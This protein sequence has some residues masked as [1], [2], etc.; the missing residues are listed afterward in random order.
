MP[1][2]GVVAL[3]GATVAVGLGGYIILYGYGIASTATTLEAVLVGGHMAIEGSVIAGLGGGVLGGS[4]V[5]A[6]FTSGCGP[7]GGGHATSATG[8]AKE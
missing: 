4:A 1:P 6:F 3:G 5:Y 7:D 2:A 8:G